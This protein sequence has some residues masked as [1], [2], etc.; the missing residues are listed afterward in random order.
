[1][2]T[3]IL[4]K[5][6]TE[7]SVSFSEKE[8][9]NIIDE[10]LKKDEKEMDVELIDQCLDL[11]NDSTKNNLKLKKKS[12]I[13]AKRLLLIAV[14]AALLLCIAVPV[15]AKFINIDTTD[16]I[17]KY[18]IDHFKIDMSKEN[19]NNYADT[20]SLKN[21]NNLSKLILPTGLLQNEYT[22]KDFKNEKIRETLDNISF[23]IES[24]EINCCVII[25]NYN[26]VNNVNEYENFAGK[27]IVPND[28]N[29]F[30]QLEVN[31]LDVLVY[32]NDD[33][34]SIYY[35]NEGSEYI[36]SLSEC[37]FDNAVSLAKTLNYI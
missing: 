12:L 3:N 13:K 19:L 1:M 7:K 15:G 32:G 35:C 24:G 23:N 36:I 10:E 26:N 2:N 25:N 11:L 27:F 20:E 29:N 5:I 30:K 31:S 14:I 33:V 17:V 21:Q 6:L 8:L 4:K 28:Y 22:I 34:S 9:R 16:N 18:C 37:D